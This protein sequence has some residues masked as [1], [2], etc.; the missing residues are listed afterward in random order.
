MIATFYKK[1][2]SLPMLTTL[3]V[4]LLA[5]VKQYGNWLYDMPFRQADEAP[6]KE[7]HACQAALS[8][9]CWIVTWGKRMLTL[10]ENLGSENKNMEG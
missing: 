10:A 9:A 1:T 4:I 2:T 3:K 8:L 6:G 7:V 5:D